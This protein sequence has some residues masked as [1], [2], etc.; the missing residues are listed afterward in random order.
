MY[1]YKFTVDIGD[2]SINCRAFTLSE[3]KDLM[4]AKVKGTLKEELLKVLSACTDAKNL[5][6]QESELLI[7]KLWA[8]SMGEV[9]SNAVWTCPVCGKETIVSMNLNYAQLEEAEDVIHAF[10]GFKIKFNY[11][12]LFDDSNIAKMIISCIDAII[13]GNDRI[14]LEDLSDQ[15]MND[16]IA[17][18]TNEEA[19]K[20]SDKLLKPS[21]YMAV[22]VVCECGHKEVHITRG[23]KEFFK[24]L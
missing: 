15:E 23:L 22:P 20:I 12:K 8:H 24:L 13:V 2:K 18:I 7:V 4:H 17:S 10:K 5:T 14:E 19:V 16:L 3:Y 11:P 1:D 6:K 9:N 21:I